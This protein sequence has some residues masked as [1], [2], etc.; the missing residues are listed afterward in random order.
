M[1]SYL[2]PAQR[3][4]NMWHWDCL[5]PRGW[6]GLGLLRGAPAPSGR[7][8]AGL[9]RVQR[10]GSGRA[11]RPT[12]AATSSATGA[13]AARP[14]NATACGPAA[15]TTTPHH[16]PSCPPHL[17]PRAMLR[18]LYCATSRMLR[19]TPGLHIH[20]GECMQECPLHPQREPEAGLGMAWEARLH[21]GRGWRDP[22][23]DGA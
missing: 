9:G 19:N 12:S 2:L 1:Q 13:A 16:R 11:R 14:D 10:A 20:D 17:P 6:P 23:A 21:C 8:P 15:T 18:G 3:I 22:A 4:L 5:G 7:H